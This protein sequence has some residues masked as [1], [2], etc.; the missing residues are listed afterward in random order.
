[1]VGIAYSSESTFL[2]ETLLEM[3]IFQTGAHNRKVTVL[4]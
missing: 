4:L 1:M 3:V 2:Q